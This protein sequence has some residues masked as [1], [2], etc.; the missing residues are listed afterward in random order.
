MGAKVCCRETVPLSEE[1]I[2][3]IGR[4]FII[5]LLV[6]NT[7][8][9]KRQSQT[10]LERV[11][12]P[13]LTFRSTESFSLGKCSAVP[14]HNKHFFFFLLGKEE[15][16]PILHFWTHIWDFSFTVCKALFYGLTTPYPSSGCRNSPWPWFWSHSHHAVTPV[17][18]EVLPGLMFQQLLLTRGLCGTCCVLIIYPATICRALLLSLPNDETETHRDQNPSS[19]G[20]NAVCAN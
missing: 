11:M 17:A 2:F 4:L 8:S 7:I 14:Q 13:A 5:Y 20:H 15:K 16:I 19:A 1:R 10:W 18:S 9:F 12:L 6:S 3:G